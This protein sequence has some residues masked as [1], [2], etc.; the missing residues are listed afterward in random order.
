MG[1]SVL[2]VLTKC[3]LHA[4]NGVVASGNGI[5]GKY[6]SYEDEGL[7]DAGICYYGNITGWHRYETPN[8][9]ELS[10]YGYPA[11]DDQTVT[12]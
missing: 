3:Q 4:K 9:K 10:N 2:P 12:R 11:A 5:A 6:V 7:A 1:G 8:A